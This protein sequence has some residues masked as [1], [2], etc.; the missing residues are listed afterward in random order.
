MAW[1]Q[2]LVCTCLL[3]LGGTLQ[4]AVITT[5]DF[6]GAAGN[7]ASTGATGV[8]S[9]LTA[10]VLDRGSGLTPDAAA[11]SISSTG[12][13][14]AGIDLTDFY[15]FTLTPNAGFTLNVDS[16]VFSERRSG[17]GIRSI[18]VRSSLDG[19]VGDLFTASVPDDTLTRRQTV[20]LGP[21]FDALSSAVTFRI[22]GFAS[23]SASTGTW[24][25]GTAAG[26]DNPNGFPANLQ[27]DGS[28]T[29]AAVPEPAS[30]FSLSVAVLSLLVTPCRA[31]SR[32]RSLLANVPR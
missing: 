22:S 7:Q 3:S 14:T 26:A 32:K 23:E 18:A 16:I 19:F 28:I 13:S 24:R 12:W 5:Y 20:N 10:S 21:A 17:T 11:N 15:G 2:L 1:R 9:G 29:A 30:V 6:T 31:N 25:L 8:A 4:A 27:V